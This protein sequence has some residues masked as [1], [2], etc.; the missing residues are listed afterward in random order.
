MGS[1]GPSTYC[2]LLI[3]VLALAAAAAAQVAPATVFQLDG[4]A[5]L[6]PADATQP[7]TTGFPV[8]GSCTYDGVSGLECDTWN[9]LNGAGVSPSGLGT[10]SSPGNSVSRV[11]MDG[12]TVTNVFTGDS[13]DTEDTS[14]WEW[15]GHK[16]PDE[17]TLLAAYAAAYEEY[18]DMVV[19]F[20]ANRESPN[21]DANIGIWFFQQSVVPQADGSFGPGVHENGDVFVLSPLPANGPTSMMVYAWAGSPGTTG[22]TDFACADAKPS[23][24]TTTPGQCADTNLEFVAGATVSTV[25]GSSAFCAVTNPTTT[26][27]TW[28]ANLAPSLFFEGGIDITYAFSQAGLPVP[29][30]LVT[31]LEETRASRTTSSELKDFSGGRF[32]TC[33][34]APQSD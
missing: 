9:L 29:E 8:Y 25:C 31:F 12:T 17:D 26:H 23:P 30:C 28:K 32:S 15:A 24:G 2:L 1:K 6:S 20:G 14:S 13:K 4:N 34:T 11:Y 27:S 5:Q 33:Q 3:G 7:S 18:N 10:G 16:L 19:I 22:G 21:G